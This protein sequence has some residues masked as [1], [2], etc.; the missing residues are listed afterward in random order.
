MAIKAFLALALLLAVTIGLLLPTPGTN[1][2][3]PTASS[4]ETIELRHG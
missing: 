2:P 3:R 4:I 1:K